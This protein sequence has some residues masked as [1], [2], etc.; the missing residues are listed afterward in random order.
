MCAS[1]ANFKP[2][3]FVELDTTNRISIGNWS[4]AASSMKFLSVRPPPEMRTAIFSGE[5]GI[6]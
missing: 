4:S 1:S 2:P 5:L 3:A 6:D